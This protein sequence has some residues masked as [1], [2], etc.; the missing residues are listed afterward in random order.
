MANLSNGFGGLPTYNFRQG[1]FEHVE[2]IGGEYMRE[3]LLNRGGVSRTTHACMA[4]CAIKCSNVFGDQTGSKVITAPLE[5]E[6]IGLMGSNLGIDSLDTIAQMNREVNDI[7]LDTIEVGAALGIACDAGIMTFGDGARALELITEIREGT[8][9][10]RVLGNGAAITGKVLGIERVPVVKG[11]AFS[12]YDPRA[13]K[14]TG[15]TYATTPQGADHTCG[16]T[17]RAKIKHTQPE[18]QVKLSRDVQIKMA[19]YDTLGACI[20]AGFGFADAPETISGLLNARYG[21]TFSDDVLVQLGRE[22]LVY[23]REFNR[24]AGFTKA[25]DRLPE[26]MTREPLPPHNTVFDVPEEELDSLFDFEAEQD[27]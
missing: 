11:Q 16:L 10:G 14:G 13:I 21:T 19:G 26:W 24:R 20:F 3:M 18:G 6:T 23:E 2:K 7:G 22:T 25:D 5:Y 8:P 4:G 12:A 1:T 27:Y 17:I 15:V 9:L